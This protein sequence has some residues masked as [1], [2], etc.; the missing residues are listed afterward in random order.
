M[1]SAPG[2]S[3]TLQR[4]NVRFSMTLPAALICLRREIGY[5]AVIVSVES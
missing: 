5:V 1:W 4:R 3:L 2:K